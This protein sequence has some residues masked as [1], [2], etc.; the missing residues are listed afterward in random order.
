MS[1]TCCSYHKL[2]IRT[3]QKAIIEFKRWKDSPSLYRSHLFLL[4]LIPTIRHLNKKHVLLKNVSYIMFFVVFFFLWLC[5]YIWFF[6][7]CRNLVHLQQNFYFFSKISEILL[8]NRNYIFFLGACIY[9]YNLTSLLLSKPDKM[10]Q[11][12][13]SLIIMYNGHEQRR[14]FLIFLD[15]SFFSNFSVLYVNWST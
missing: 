9:D 11:N 4:T 5:N 14:R 1:I 8:L 7:G 6:E 15:F 3:W 10:E 13:A 2:T 12:I